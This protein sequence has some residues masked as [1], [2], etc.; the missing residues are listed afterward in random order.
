MKFLDGVL[1]LNPK[2]RFI[3]DAH[4]RYPIVCDGTETLEEMKKWAA[5]M[6]NKYFK[7]TLR[8]DDGQ[9]YSCEGYGW[10]GA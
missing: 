9:Y 7:L 6:T 4:L 10:K 8:G 3:L 1:D 2:D 5:S